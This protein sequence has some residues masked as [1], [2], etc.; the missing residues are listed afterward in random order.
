MAPNATTIPTTSGGAAATTT[1]TTTT[2][3]K[4]EDSQQARR[5]LHM[6]SAASNKISPSQSQKTITP[7]TPNKISSQQPSTSKLARSSQTASNV[8]KPAD[9]QPSSNSSSTSSSSCSTAT[10]TAQR[11]QQQQHQQHQQQQRNM[12]STAITTEKKWAKNDPGNAAK[13]TGSSPTVI[14]DDG[15]STQSHSISK[16]PRLRRVIA[17]D[18][19]GGGAGRWMCGGC[20]CAC[21]CEVMCM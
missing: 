16:S 14:H 12:E 8:H 11:Q 3:A 5:D 1:T 4:T 17:D 2:T 15:D 13:S 7:T 9:T 19:A 10:A 6:S 18:A 21:A 20:A